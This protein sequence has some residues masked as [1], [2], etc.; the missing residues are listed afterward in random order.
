MA[1]ECKKYVFEYAHVF[2]QLLIDLLPPKRICGEIGFC[3][4]TKAEPF[5]TLPADHL[6]D[7]DIPDAVKKTSNE[8]N[9]HFA[10]GICKKVI[11]VAENM[12]ENNATEEEIVHEVE[13]VCYLFPHDMS[14][15]CKDFVHSYGPAVVTML[16]DAVKPESVCII[17]RCCPKGISLSTETA[18]IEQVPKLSESEIC[19]VCTLV[20]KY[21]DDELE[22]NETQA[23]IGSMLAKGCQFLPEALVYPCDELVSQY[24]PA[25]VRLLIQMMEPTF[26]HV[27]RLTLWAKKHVPGVLATGA[28]VQRLQ[29]SVRPPNT[30]SN[31]YG[32]RV[33][34]SRWTKSG[35]GFNESIL[36]SGWV[37]KQ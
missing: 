23:Q 7:L 2:V 24:E 33:S 19:H 28:Q 14:A 30:A 17:L 18:A 12:V 5:H 32:T 27:L 29:H 16:L 9:S 26:E 11:Q 3:D 35:C 10:C 15:E 13:N 8:E 36:E 4:S 21:V 31:I 6:R 22:K 25:A 37:G 34:S 1:D 20:I